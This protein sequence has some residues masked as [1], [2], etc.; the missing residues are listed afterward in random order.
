MIAF[1]VLESY[2][3]ALTPKEIYQE[4]SPGVVFVY[5]SEGSGKGSG[6]TGSIINEDGLVITNAH[7]FT[8]KDYHS[9]KWVSGIQTRL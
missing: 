2:A 4:V 6:G 5:A 3:Y 7:I 9:L 1:W 8:R